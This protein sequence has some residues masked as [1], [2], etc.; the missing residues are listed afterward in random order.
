[1]FGQHPDQ[2]GE[3][4]VDGNVERGAHGVVQKVNIRPLAQQQ[5]CNLCLI[6]KKKQGGAMSR[7]LY[8][9]CIATFQEKRR[10]CVCALSLTQRQC[11][12]TL[13]L[14]LHP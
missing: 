4:L 10:V 11:S 9:E 14:R 3:A 8:C 6:A 12:V 7:H 5:P 2:V 1:M 13:Y